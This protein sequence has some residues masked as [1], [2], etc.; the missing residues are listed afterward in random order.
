MEDCVFCKIVS[1]KIPCY[2]IYENEEILSFLDVSP[3]SKGHCLVIPKKHDKTI[4]NLENNEI[5]KLMVSVKEVM[6]LIKEK[7]ECDGFNV[8][9]NNGESAGQVVPHLHVHIIPRFE[10]DNG[11]SMHSIINN[12]SELKVE[13]VYSLFE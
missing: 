1:G 5:E 8:G 4:F 7:L 12:P 9:W 13:E 2:K 10:G 3:C 6:K 11:G